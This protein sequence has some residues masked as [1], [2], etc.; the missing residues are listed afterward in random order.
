[1]RIAVSSEG[2]EGL[3]AQVSAHF[4]RCPYYTLVDVDD[5]RA[6]A[7]QVVANP[8]YPDHVPGVVPRFIRDQGAE[9]MLTGGMGQRAI[10][11]F[12]EL[13][14]RAVTG[15]VGTVGTAVDGYLAGRLGAAAPCRDHGHDCGHDDDGSPPE[16]A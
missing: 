8:H 12:G 14:I 7:V 9:V 4:G 2:A 10:G 11:L 6:A 13:G 3:E 15:A 16:R 1:M 5:C